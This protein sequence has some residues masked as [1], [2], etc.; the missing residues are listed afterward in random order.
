MS[1]RSRNKGAAYELE[2]AK[3]LHALTG[4]G[5]RRNLVQY[6]TS[7]RADLVPDDPAWPFAIEC[8]RAAVLNGMLGSWQVQAK[9]AA[10]RV[11][12]FPVVVFRLDKART[13]VSVPMEAIGAAFGGSPGDCALWVET[14]LDGLAYLA[15]EIMARD[16]LRPAHAS[17]GD[18][19]WHPPH[20]DSVAREEAHPSNEVGRPASE[21]PAAPEHHRSS[22]E[23][24]CQDH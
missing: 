14:D 7:E 21:A 3:A 4:I 13:R 22:E 1:A 2:V 16:A 24:Q 18:W 9:V 15:R 11:S 8:K 10:R 6:Q 12:L 17:P 5:F 19:P 23:Q 20:S